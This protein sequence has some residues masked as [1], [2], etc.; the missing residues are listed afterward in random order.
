M[1]LN[2]E[3]KPS[4]TRNLF[5]LYITKIK[6]V[7][8]EDA[9]FTDGTPFYR[10]YRRI[11]GGYEVRL[12]FRTARDNTEAV[13]VVTAD[14]EYPMRKLK[15][16][17]MFDYYEMKMPCTEGMRYYFK[18][19]DGVKTVYYNKRGVMHEVQDYYNFCF[20]PAF[21]TP[22]WAKGAVFLQIFTDLLLQRQ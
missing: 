12:R 21:T 17:A 1:N 11:G 2:L 7:L 6:P 13:T 5:H 3:L 14:R 15:S 9:L 19:T 18:I 8:I 20:A 22:D 4:E 16:E 10:K